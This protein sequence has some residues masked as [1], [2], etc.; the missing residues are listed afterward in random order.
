MGERVT[1]RVGVENID[2]FAGRS[3]Q[4]RLDQPGIG[5]PQLLVVVVVVVASVLVLVLLLMLY[6]HAG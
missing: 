6:K 5:N 1:V 3:R 2:A 4:C